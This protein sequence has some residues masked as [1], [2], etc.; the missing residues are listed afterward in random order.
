M[1]A[2][3]EELESHLAGDVT[4]HCFCWIIQRAD[5]VLHGF[6][7]HDMTLLVEDVSC[8]P[9]TGMSA[10]EATSQLG[11]AV[12]SMEVEGALS[13]L[14]IS[15]TAIERGA[16]DDA[17][18]EIWLVNWQS[19][20]QRVLL[21]RSVI[22]KISRSGGRFVAELKS[23]TAALDAVKG[24]RVMRSC[25]A[26]PGDARCGVDID[27]TGFRAL[28]EVTEIVGRTDIRASGLVGY[29]PRWFDHGRL[30]WS[31]GANSGTV[32]T[33]ARQEDERLVLYMPPALEIRVGDKF[34][35]YAGCDKS[36]AQCKAKFGNGVNFRGFPH[37][38][39][40]DAAY[41]YAD[42]TSVFDGGALVP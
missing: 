37:L 35:L 18:V 40:N 11:L 21:R 28:C 17:T 24:R 12:D 22:G 4:S 3:P 15:E 20:E 39:G 26:Q 38:P 30:V 1:K 34:I 41:Q 27:Q 33:V 2:L 31:S 5:G 16:F 9:Q 36:F 42:G 10:S 32:S 6:T 29:E 23:S 19:P 14:A 13:S 8:E 7:D 25:D